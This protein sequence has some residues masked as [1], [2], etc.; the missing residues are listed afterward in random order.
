M[1]KAHALWITAFFIIYLLTF[2]PNFGIMND[3]KFIGF[4]PQSLAWVLLLNAIN[5]VIIF[6]IYFKFFKPFAQ[7]VE[8]KMMKI[9]QEG[10]QT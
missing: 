6:V 4:L 3:L 5:T 7:N 2:L 1:R 9:E 8:E 10:E